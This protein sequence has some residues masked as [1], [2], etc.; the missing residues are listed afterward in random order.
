[1]TR[2]DMESAHGAPIAQSGTQ[3]AG[4]VN[5]VNP[6]GYDPISHDGRSVSTQRRGGGTTEHGFSFQV[7]MAKAVRVSFFS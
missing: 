2:A 4:R 3:A 6:W 7:A 1:M 5:G